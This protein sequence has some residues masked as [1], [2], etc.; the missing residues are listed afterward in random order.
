MMLVNLFSHPSRVLSA[1]FLLALSGCANEALKN[2]LANSREAVDQAK[3]AGA[4]Q[5][6]PRELD[7]AVNKLNQA[8]D[9]SKKWSKT[10]AMRLA[11]EAQ[12]DAN[13]ARA[14]TDSAQANIAAAE[15]QKSNQIMREAYAAHT[16]TSRG[17]R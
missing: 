9:A 11:Q 12:V 14:K 16:R 15:L 5:T 17:T 8:D 2:Q 13:L 7:A 10:D 3:I 4:Q 6:A 1:C